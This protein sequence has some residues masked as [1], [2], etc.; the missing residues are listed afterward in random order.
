[1]P[2]PDKLINKTEQDLADIGEDIPQSE[3]TPAEPEA[4]IGDDMRQIGAF[5]TDLYDQLPEAVKG[6]QTMAGDIAGYGKAM[7]GGAEVILQKGTKAT[8]DFITKHLVNFAE[9]NTENTPTGKN[10]QAMVIPQMQS[11]KHN[12]SGIVTTSDDTENFYDFIVNYRTGKLA[13]TLRHKYHTVKPDSDMKY[14]TT[15][16]PEFKNVIDRFKRHWKR[17]FG[18]DFKSEGHNIEVRFMDNS[19]IKQA[20]KDHGDPN[21]KGLAAMSGMAGNITLD[22]FVDVGEDMDSPRYIYMKK[23]IWDRLSE[24]KKYVLFLHELGHAEFNLAHDNSAKIMNTIQFNS[25]EHIREIFNIFKKSRRKKWNPDL[26][27]E[28]RF[29]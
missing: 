10:T 25:Q 29:R 27:Q 13:D 16:E 20:I 19:D 11:G 6:A 14:V 24:R 28:G 2:T 21:K 18:S 7:V 17:H 5:F 22:A 23:E 26:K 15:S 4:R 1:M 3:P 12:I 9:S 8:K